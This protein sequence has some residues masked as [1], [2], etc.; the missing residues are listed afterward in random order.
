MTVNGSLWQ[1][2]AVFSC[3]WQSVLVSGSVWY[4]VADCGILWQSVADCG[5]LLQSVAYF[6]FYKLTI[7][8]SLS[9]AGT[10]ADRALPTILS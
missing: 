9:A 7:S 5:S 10:R 8:I 6:N 1:T 4:S 3:L 2:V